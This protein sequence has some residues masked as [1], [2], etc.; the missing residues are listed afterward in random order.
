MD[1]ITLIG[2]LA[3][4]LTTISFVPQALKT[5]QTRHTK[6]ISLTMYVVF[7]AGVLMWLVY[8]LYLDSMP[9]ILAN[10]VTLVLA[11]IILVLKI[12]HG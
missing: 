4:I 10:G 7:T 5:W 8:G 1:F 6:D 2:F 11:F 3:A 9:M 12:K